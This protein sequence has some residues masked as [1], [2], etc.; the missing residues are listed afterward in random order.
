M[1]SFLF[2]RHVETEDHICGRLLKVDQGR[3]FC[4]KIYG[5]R[6]QETLHAVR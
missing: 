2:Q 1:Q 5:T 3:I 6:K 4:V